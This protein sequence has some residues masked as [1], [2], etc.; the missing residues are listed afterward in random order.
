MGERNEVFDA[1]ACGMPRVEEFQ[2][3][4]SI[5][6]LVAVLV[7]HGLAWKQGATQ[8]VLHDGSVF[9]HALAVAI[10]MRLIKDDIAVAID[11]PIPRP[12]TGKTPRRTIGLVR[13]SP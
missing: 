2:V 12:G 5:V 7:M 11:V 9:K 4:K 13:A 6:G 8:V 3:L 1:L 10:R